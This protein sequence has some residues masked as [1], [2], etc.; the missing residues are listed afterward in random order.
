MPTCH[1]LLPVTLQSLPVEVLAR[2]MEWIPKDRR[3]AWVGGLRLV[4][5]HVRLG[6]ACFL[7]GEFSSAIQVSGSKDGV[8]CPARPAHALHRY[9]LCSAPLMSSSV[10]DSVKGVDFADWKEAVDSDALRVAEAFPMLERVINARK[11]T[12]RVVVAFSHLQALSAVGLTKCK[13]LSGACLTALVSAPQLKTL[14]LNRCK[15]VTARVLQSLPLLPTL[16]ELD[17]SGCPRVDDAAIAAVVAQCPAVESL[18][19]TCCRRLSEKCAGSLLLLSKLRKVVLNDCIGI[20]DEALA[21]FSSYLPRLETLGLSGNKSVKDFAV[22]PQLLGNLTSLNLGFVELTEAGRN[23]L[24]EAKRVQELYISGCGR[25]TDG[26]LGGLGTLS[27]LRILSFS[28]YY[29]ASN[30]GFQALGRLP[31][32][33]ELRIY[34]ANITDSNIAALLNPQSSTSSAGPQASLRRVELSGCRRLTDI[35]LLLLSTLVR[36]ESLDLTC[37]DGITD[38]GLAPLAQLRGLTK[39]NLNTSIQ[40]HS[41]EHVARIQS[42]KSL[43]LS[44]CKDVGDES[45]KPFS[46]H[47]NLEEVHLR[48]CYRLT[49]FGMNYLANV[50]RLWRLDVGN[51]PSIKSI[52]QFQD[53]PSLRYL[54]LKG[55]N[56]KKKEVQQFQERTLVCHVDF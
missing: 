26:L 44:G 21:V 13:R 30:V 3:L 43:I 42:L 7:E 34:Y 31:G 24:V 2:V 9:I 12:D 36:L 22:A 29:E 56:V 20:G 5:Q 8:W 18:D 46:V 49:D 53:F 19:L 32:L 33:E 41:L 14:T 50:P 39:L 6:V 28:N 16:K 52:S 40:G 37:T 38:A 27:N 35:T 1:S 15:W 4:S 51:C 47:R 23:R 25:I 54:N 45:L 17:L 48:C 10:L 55:C 11:V